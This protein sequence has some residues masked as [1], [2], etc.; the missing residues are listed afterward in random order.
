MNLLDVSRLLQEIRNCA[1]DAEIAHSLEDELHEKVL[2]AIASGKCGD[3]A[4][5]AKLALTSKE[6]DFPRWYA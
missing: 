4:G 1:G 6:I 5:C 2:D 3:P